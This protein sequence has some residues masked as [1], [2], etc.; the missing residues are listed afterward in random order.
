M[1]KLKL[2]KEVKFITCI[3]CFAMLL[4]MLP[5]T[6]VIAEED[7]IQQPETVSITQSNDVLYTNSYVDLTAEYSDNENADYQWQIYLGNAD[8]WVNIADAK[9]ASLKVTYAM[10]ANTLVNEEAQLRCNITEDDNTVTSEVIKLEISDPENKQVSDVVDVTAASSYANARINNYSLR[11]TSTFDLDVDTQENASNTVEI[12]NVVVNYLFQD[13]MVA[14]DPYVASVTKGEQFSANAPIPDVLG[15]IATYN[16]AEIT[17]VLPIDIIPSGNTY[18]TVIYVPTYVKYSVNFY[19]QHI[20]DD[21]YDLVKTTVIDYNNLG[22]IS[23]DYAKKTGEVI[24]NNLSSLYTPAGFYSLK[25]D[26]S[27]TVAADG[28][29]EVNIYYDRYYY[30]MNFELDG[31][32]GVEP[33]YARFGYTIGEIKEPIKSGYIFSGWKK[34]GS[35]EIGS[36][37]ATMPAENQKYYAVWTPN[38]TAKVTVVFWGENADDTEYSYIK[39]S[40]VDV[41]PGNEFIYSEDG[42]LICALEEHTHSMENDCYKFICTKEKH[43]HIETCYTCGIESHSHGTSCY[44]GVKSV[45]FAGIG[46]PNNPSNGYISREALSIDGKVIYINGTWYKYTGSTSTGSIAPTTCGKTEKIHVHD[47]SCLGCSKIE[48]THSIE[49]NCYELICTKTEHTHSSDCYLSGAGLDSNLWTFDKSDTVTVAADGSSVVNV[50]YKRT[51]KTLTFKY[52]YKNRNYQSTELITAKWGSD[53]SVQ[54]KK[55]ASNADS[56]FWSASDEG[57]DPYTNYFGIMPQSSATYYNRGTNGKTGAMTYWGQDLNG[58]YTVKLFTVSGV[59]GYHVTDE[60]RYEFNGYTYHHGTKNNSDCDGAAFYYTRN[61]Y[62]LTF[63]DGYKDV[64]TDSVK[65]Q[66]SLSNYSSYVPN[67]PSA[68]EPGSVTFG[69]WYLNPEC[70]GVEYK[71]DEHKMPADNLLL[72]A[73]WV[74]VKHTVKFYLDRDAFD[75]KTQLSSHLALTVDHGS[76]VTPTPTTPVNGAYSFVGWFYDENGVEKAIDF[77]NMP[78]RKDLEVYG[79]WTSN[80]LMKYVISYVT[81][82]DG[83]YV[84]I[85]DDTVGYTL[86]G[87]S[88]TFDAKAG[89]DLYLDYQDGYFPET[90]SHTI[91]KIDIN[92]NKDNPEKN[93]YQFIYVPKESVQYTVKYLEIG[94]NNELASPKTVDSNKAVVTETYIPISGYVPDAYQKRLILSANGKNELI[95]WYEQDNENAPVSVIHYVENPSGT[96]YTTYKEIFS[97]KNRIDSEYSTAIL[98]ITDYEFEKA[99]VN[100]QVVTPVDGK[101]TSNVESSG[102]RIQIYYKRKVSDLTITKTVNGVVDPNQDFIFKVRLNTSENPITVVIHGSDMTENTGSVVIPD[103][104]IGTSILVEEITEWSW[105]YQPNSLTQRTTIVANGNTVDFTNTLTNNKWLSQDS[106]V[107]NQ[108]SINTKTE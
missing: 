10:V 15:Y 68:K 56:T 67:V 28:S 13:G 57:G 69:G 34:Q 1:K 70:T 78:V 44:T 103:L 9:S 95:F 30:L 12:V 66:A 59:G 19:E 96:G 53:I 27:I 20:E 8:T 58:E 54:Y 102:L 62:T 51:E 97:N 2:R 50:Y 14:A 47:E 74:P 48:H 63:N 61:S 89:D 6:N 26:P 40:Q 32:Y 17:G 41:K 87:N 104:R 36:I 23:K 5:T 84:K 60:D 92:D 52:N 99:T 90:T 16:N 21:N 82:K 35:E 79:K 108:F 85:A 80:E 71:L 106:N 7:S 75:N 31:G 22:D 3:L 76:L 93:V 72:Y 105:R 100:D 42:T 101:I 86:A 29:T 64:K 39:S 65:F 38:D 55:I 33:V 37:P 91:A 24:P 81:L 88:K 43:T 11:N 4:G 77:A 46:A 45:S 83:S 25:Y 94:T 18:Y 49:N 98:D 73:K 107:V